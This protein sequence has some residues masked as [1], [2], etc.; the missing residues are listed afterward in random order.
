MDVLKGKFYKSYT[1]ISRYQ[2]IPYS[3]NVLDDKYVYWLTSHLRKNNSYA[4]VKITQRDTLDSLSNQYYG[5]PDY[6]WVIADFNDMP[7]PF[8]ELW[9]NYDT[10]DIPTLGN[11]SY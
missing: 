5:R 6:Y 9:G 7:D 1:H 8:V 2:P 4:T 11:I 10:L 3:Y